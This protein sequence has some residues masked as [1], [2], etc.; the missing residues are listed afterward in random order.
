MPYGARAAIDDALIVSP[1]QLVI[2][3]AFTAYVWAVRD[4]VDS[5]L[6]A[7]EAMRRAQRQSPIR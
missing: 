7:E 3:E 5:K 6:T 2:E 1:V 4:V